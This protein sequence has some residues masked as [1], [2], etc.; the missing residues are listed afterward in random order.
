MV[1][2]PTSFVML[3]RSVQD[4]QRKLN[5][6]PAQVVEADDKREKKGGAGRSG[7]FLWLDTEKKQQSATNVVKDG[8]WDEED[9]RKTR[10]LAGK[11]QTTR[12]FSKKAELLNQWLEE[13]IQPPLGESRTQLLKREILSVIRMCQLQIGGHAGL[14]VALFLSMVTALGRDG[15]SVYHR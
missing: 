8:D 9:N 6:L 10:E 12:S 14:I 4:A 2:M 15:K 13:V 7:R 1:G 11:L 3:D 5:T